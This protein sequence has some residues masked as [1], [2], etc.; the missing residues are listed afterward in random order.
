MPEVIEDHNWPHRPDDMGNRGAGGRRKLLGRVLDLVGLSK[1]EESLEHLSPEDQFMRELYPN[2]I[3][4]ELSQSSEI[5]DCYLLAAFKSLKGKPEL[6]RAIITKTV[7]KLAPG[8][9]EVNF[10]GLDIEPIEVTDEIIQFW[11]SQHEGVRAAKG[12]IILEVAYASFRSRKKR[13]RKGVTMVRDEDDKLAI[14][15]GDTAEALSH[16]MGPLAVTY[17]IT[18]PK[19]AEDNSVVAVGG[20]AKSVDFFNNE[21]DPDGYIVAAGTPNAPDGDKSHRTVEGVRIYNNHVHSVVGYDKATKMVEIANPHDTSKTF[22]LPLYKFNDVFGTIRYIKIN[23]LAQLLFY[24]PKDASHSDI[25]QV[26][27]DIFLQHTDVYD[28]CGIK[29]DHKYLIDSQFDQFISFYDDNPRLQTILYNKLLPALEQE[30]IK[31]TPFGVP[32]GEV[33][34]RSKTFRYTEPFSIYLGTTK[35][36]LKVAKYQGRFH[37][38]SFNGSTW[39]GVGTLSSIGRT[40]IG[41]D[42]RSGIRIDKETVSSEHVFINVSGNKITV[43][44]NNSTNGTYLG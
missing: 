5:G 23:P 6:M 19:S 24:L 39:E 20:G 36:H 18:I 25:E 10:L 40:I 43:M 21:F 4:S 44:D 12:D 42:G 17:S 29:K 28:L 1:N 11:Q 34:H 27:D 8:K 30:G 22:K 33:K 37:V 35:A 9:W 7:H 38:A 13:G 16:L 3:D 26:I 32:V 31:L 41:R 15:G 14:D 2:G